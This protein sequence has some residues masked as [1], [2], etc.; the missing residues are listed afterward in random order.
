V[1]PPIYVGGY[2]PVRSYYGYP[3]YP[4]YGYYGPYDGYY[5]SGIEVS[6]GW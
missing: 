2:Y 4:Y 1:Y 6:V 3:Y 5:G